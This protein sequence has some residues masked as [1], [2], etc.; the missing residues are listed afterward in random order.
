MKKIQ[1]KI[2]DIQQFRDNT[3]KLNLRSGNWDP[4]LFYRWLP[5]SY[6]TWNVDEWEV[7]CKCSLKDPR[8]GCRLQ[9][10]RS[11]RKVE[12]FE[13]MTQLSYYECKKFWA[14]ACPIPLFRNLDCTSGLRQFQ[15]ISNLYSRKSTY[16]HKRSQKKPCITSCDKN[17]STQSFTRMYHHTAKISWTHTVITNTVSAPP[18]L[19]G[20][21]T[22]FSSKF[23]KVGDQK[24]LSACGDLKVLAMDICLQRGEAYYIFCQKRT[25][26]LRAQFQMLI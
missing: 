9:N 12:D 4:R 2:Q 22:T 16:A 26:T 3:K 15:V 13:V 7:G 14:V 6:S 8:Q 11:Q 1:A 23:W 24:K 5:N 10:G 18:F 25:L 17:N 19:L 21:G 20:G